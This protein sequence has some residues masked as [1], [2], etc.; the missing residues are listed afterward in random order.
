MIS[1]NETF[2]YLTFSGTFGRVFRL[3][4][5]RFD[6]FMGISLVFFVPYAIITYVTGLAFR[7]DVF[8]KGN[9]DDILKFF[10]MFILEFFIYE[11]ACI[12]GQ[13][14]ISIAVA[15]IY[16]DRRVEVGSCLKQAWRAKWALICS[17][18]LVNALLFASVALPILVVV[19]LFV[20]VGVGIAIAVSLLAFACLGGAFYGY[21]GLLLTSP[22]IAIE[23]IASPVK[24][25]KRSW[26][27]S[28]GSRCYLLSTMIA[29]FLGS[30]MIATIFQAVFG[31]TVGGI[32]ALLLT[33]FYLPLQ[34]IT[35]TVLYLN[36]RIGRESM[37]QQVLMGD[38]VNNEPPSSRFR[39]DAQV[40]IG[41][42]PTEPLD[43]RHV[44]LMDEEEIAY[45]NE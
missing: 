30:R 11:L 16:I 6:L 43:Y 14:A 35:E 27:L 24:G 21:L 20:Y 42:V 36:L 19:L 17:S 10:N 25:I 5:D 18:I 8:E 12:I 40:E 23:N 41:Y 37:N 26:E 34:G 44:P 39:N 38:L 29:L 32:M 28:T 2:E 9:P 15:E 45:S 3:F 31:D 1:E 22:A 7:A 13:G 4:F 33:A